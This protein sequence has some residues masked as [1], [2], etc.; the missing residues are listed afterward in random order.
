[1]F[2]NR[3]AAGVQLAERL[4]G[5]PLDHPIVLAIPRGGVV[6]GAALAHELNAELDVVLSRKLR[7]PFQSEVSIGAIAEDGE[8]YLNEQASESLEF[9]E[10]Y[11]SQERKRQLAEICRCREL[12][13]AVRPPAE[14]AGRSVIVTDDG[15]VTGATMLAALQM[16]QW[17]QPKEIVV[18]V[19][20]IS[21]HT[22]RDVR[23]WCQEV[24]ALRLPEQMW[25]VGQFYEE[26]AELDDQQMVE[27]LKQAQRPNN[28]PSQLPL[29]A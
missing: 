2:R 5:R 6:V 14:L 21:T 4:H 29:G 7:A 8:A 22:L 13:R 24:I 27:L 10:H 15:V 17:K 12:V 16:L 3:H 18:A 25:S 23:Q 20:V 1:M 26:F 9:S 19:P 11:F 28:S